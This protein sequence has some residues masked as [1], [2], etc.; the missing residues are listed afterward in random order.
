MSETYLKGLDVRP[1]ADAQLL[2]IAMQGLDVA[3]EDWQGK[4]QG[5]RGEFRSRATDEL[6]VMLQCV[7]HF[8]DGVSAWSRE[9]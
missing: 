1:E 6:L 4:N 3:L 8:V 5:W 2:D 9:R 7:I